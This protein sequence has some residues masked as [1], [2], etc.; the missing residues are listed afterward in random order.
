MTEQ[1]KEHKSDFVSDIDFHFDQMEIDL[2]RSKLGNNRN[3][4]LTRLFDSLLTRIDFLKELIAKTP[5]A[6]FNSLFS[7][8]KGMFKLDKTI[9]GF[10][11]TISFTESLILKNPGKLGVRITSKIIEDGEEVS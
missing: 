7:E 2:E 4:I 3:F 5:R 8:M 11:I 9:D 6:Y 1:K 10:I